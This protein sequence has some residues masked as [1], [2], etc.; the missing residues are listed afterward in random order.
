MEFIVPA[1]IVGI[2]IVVVLVWAKKTNE[3]QAERMKMLSQ[4][5]FDFIKNSG[6]TPYKGAKNNLETVGVLT[7]I[8]ESSSQ[9]VPVDFIF[10]NCCT[11]KYELGDSKIS[12]DVIEK[13]SLKVGDYIHITFKFKDGIINSVNEIL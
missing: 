9:K 2:F 1:I 10:W 6:Y 5:Q 11:Q 8:K 12:R 7:N 13:R 3:R 4:E